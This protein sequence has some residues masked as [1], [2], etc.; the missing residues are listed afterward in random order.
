MRIGIS[1]R[2]KYTFCALRHQGALR[3]KRSRRRRAPNFVVPTPWGTTLVSDDSSGTSIIRE[4]TLDGVASVWS[5][6]VPTPKGMVFSLDNRTLYVAATF[7]DVGLWRVLVSDAGEAGTPEK[8]VSFEV[9]SIPYGVAIDSEGNVYVALNLND[10]IAQ[11]KP[12]G[13]V[14]VIADGVLKP[15]SFAFGQG[16]RVGIG[17]PGPAQ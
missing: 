1:M 13:T 12:D 10:E 3:C 17:I 4:V 16:W 5:D 7:D 2:K 9:G 11:V 14:T 8:W 15:A 6:G